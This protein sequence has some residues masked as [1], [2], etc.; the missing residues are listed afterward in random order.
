VLINLKN[1]MARSGVPL[2]GLASMLGISEHALTRKLEEKSDFTLKQMLIIQK[3]LPGQSMDHLF[4]A[5]EDTGAPRKG[6]TGD[7]L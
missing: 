2:G 4:A 7:E 3:A 5:G 6:V 1:A